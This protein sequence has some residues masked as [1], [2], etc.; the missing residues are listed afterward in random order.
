MLESKILT[1][2]QGLDLARLESQ[3]R[4]AF[5]DGLTSLYTPTLINDGTISSHPA[6]P[7][8]PSPT[9]RGPVPARA[10]PVPPRPS[11]QAPQHPASA[12]DAQNRYALRS[13]SLSAAFETISKA[14]SSI[15]SRDQRTFL[16]LDSPTLLLATDPAITAADL[17]FFTT[18]LRASVHSAL[19]VAEADK[20]LIAA[21]APEA[22]LATPDY[23]S[24][25]TK[26]TAQ[27]L[28]PLDTQ[29]AAFVVGQA[30]CARWVVGLRGLDTGV[31]RDI[32][33]VLTVRRGSFWDEE[34]D[35]SDGRDEGKDMEVLYRVGMDGSVKV[36]ERG[37]GEIG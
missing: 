35:R 16:I 29:H 23:L 9:A 12:P 11:S 27:A 31:A 19:L 33:G 4:F 32:S 7:S 21:A 28:T 17:S 15:Q 5:V 6:L 24:T 25:N 37:A 2:L 18:R 34:V 1:Y 22:F 14:I 20:P 3:G 10:A 36:F 8:R 13:P 30:H 26:A